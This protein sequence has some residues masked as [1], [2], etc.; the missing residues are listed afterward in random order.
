MRE[1]AHPVLERD[2]VSVA[3][4]A[5]GEELLKF[6]DVNAVVPAVVDIDK[7]SHA[8]IGIGL[9][10]DVGA[11]CDEFD[12]L[13]GVD[14]VG[15]CDSI[16]GVRHQASFQMCIQ[17]SERAIDQSVLCGSGGGSSRIQDCQVISGNVGESRVGGERGMWPP[18][19][20][21]RALASARGTGTSPA[22]KRH[23][24]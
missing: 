10:Y 3:C 23:T 18:S 15:A 22:D 6:R 20:R 13:L 1:T 17:R 14:Q 7:M 16:D 19:L 9:S 24:S 8:R 2:Q 21:S 4:T 12:V 11:S 5:L